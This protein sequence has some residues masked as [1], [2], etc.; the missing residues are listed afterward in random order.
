MPDKKHSLSTKYN[1]YDDWICLLCQNHNYSFRTVC[2]KPSHLGNRCHI[3]TKEYNAYLT[4]YQQGLLPAEPANDQ[5]LPNE[6]WLTVSETDLF[7][8]CLLLMINDE[9]W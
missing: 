3:Q 4:L 8:N 9:P 1:K 5:T 7:P 6:N 2:T